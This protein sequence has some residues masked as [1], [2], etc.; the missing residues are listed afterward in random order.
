LYLSERSPE[1]NPFSDCHSLKLVF[2]IRHLHPARGLVCAVAIILHTASALG[3]T[4]PGLQ[5]EIVYEH[6]SSNSFP[7][8]RDGNAATLFLDSDP[9]LPQQRQLRPS[10]PFTP[11]THG[12]KR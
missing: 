4:S 5:T 8:A 6:A 3:G 9:G 1:Q 12:A 11:T 7:L 2:R 10:Q